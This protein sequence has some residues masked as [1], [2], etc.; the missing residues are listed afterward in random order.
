MN[1][2]Y[3]LARYYYPYVIKNWALQTYHRHAYWKHKWKRTEVFECGC[4][5]FEGFVCEIC[6]TQMIIGHVGFSTKP[7]ESGDVV[8]YG[9]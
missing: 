5:G 6:H 8:E 9:Y 7:I 2:L 3:R 4:C 1:E